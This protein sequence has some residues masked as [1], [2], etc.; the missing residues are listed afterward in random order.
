[1]IGLATT[2][3]NVIVAGGVLA[4]TLLAGILAHESAHVAVLHASGIRYEV[5]WH[6]DR[7]AAGTDLA[8]ASPLA[9]V[10]PRPV[11]PRGS[12]RAVR[13]AAIAPLALA[14]PLSLVVLG[15]VP[16]PLASGDPYMAAVTVGW[17][18]CALPSPQDFAV[19]CHGLS[20]AE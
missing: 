10:T 6:P 9:T 14:T 18:A 4:V 17:A 8:I 16:D 1:M 20:A 12:Q 3:V 5:S 13:V 19:F 2:I 15:V 11:S 7:R